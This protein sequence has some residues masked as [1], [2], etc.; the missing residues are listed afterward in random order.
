MHRNLFV[1]FIIKDSGIAT[2]Q[3]CYIN[4]SCHATLQNGVLPGR[5][6]RQ[7]RPAGPV[8][9]RR[10]MRR[11]LPIVGAAKV[12]FGWKLGPFMMTP[13]NHSLVRNKKTPTALAATDYRKTTVSIGLL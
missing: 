3:C 9:I 13:V 7:L 11:L 8:N 12:N 4:C 1:R 6:N 10:K 5:S 2:E